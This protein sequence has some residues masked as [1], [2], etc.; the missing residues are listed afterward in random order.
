MPCLILVLALLSPRL[1][2]FAMALFSDVLSRSMDG[3]ILPLIGFF[4]LPW[5]T[6]AWALAWSSGT[7]EV[8]GF[9][10]FI[11]GFFFLVDLGAI[12]GTARGRE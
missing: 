11:V 8:A 2:I 6:L 1:A 12:G 10:W 5:T 3:W 9:E 4:V 7:N